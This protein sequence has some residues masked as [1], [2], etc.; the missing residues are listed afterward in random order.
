MCSALSIQSQKQ[1]LWDRDWSLDSLP[2]HITTLKAQKN[3][4]SKWA[5]CHIAALRKRAN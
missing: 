1:F 5:Q 2:I 3:K 4:K